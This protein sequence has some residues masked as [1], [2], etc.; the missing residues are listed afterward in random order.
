M[1]QG[2]NDIPITINNTRGGHVIQ[3]NIISGSVYISMLQL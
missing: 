3:N 2:K 1:D